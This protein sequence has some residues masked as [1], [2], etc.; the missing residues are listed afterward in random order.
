MS[1]VSS[2]LLLSKYSQWFSW[3]N[4]IIGC[5]GIEFSNLFYLGNLHFLDA[6]VH[7]SFQ[8]CEFLSIVSINN[9]SE[10][11][12]H[13]SPSEV[14]LMPIL[15]LLMM[16]HCHLVFLNSFYFLLLFLWLGNF[17]WLVFKFIDSFFLI[18]SIAEPLGRI[19]YSVIVFLSSRISF[20]SLYL[21][22]DIFILLTYN[23]PDFIYLFICVLL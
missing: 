11:S 1:P 18:K 15:V 19:F 23:F 3:Y 2:Y 20:Y 4:L 13:S 7:F 21:F 10:T 14:L 9:L 5:L 17:R 16:S 12:C 8:I 22:A 6:D